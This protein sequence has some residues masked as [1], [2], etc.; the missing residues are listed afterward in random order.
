MDIAA[1]I[2]NAFSSGKKKNYTTHFY[3]HAQ[4]SMKALRTIIDFLSASCENKNSRTKAMWTHEINEK[5][6]F[7]F[8]SLWPPAWGLSSLQ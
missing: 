6:Y 1:P 5:A 4:K 3:K 7:I 8:L 2:I